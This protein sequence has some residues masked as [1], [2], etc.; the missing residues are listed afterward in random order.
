[1][2][3]VELRRPVRRLV[4]GASLV[5]AGLLL[6]DAFPAAAQRVV[7]SPVPAPTV[8]TLS[9]GIRVV[10][11]PGSS[12]PWVS[13]RIAVRGGV[14]AE[15]PD[16]GGVAGLVA[17]TLL[18]ASLDRPALEVADT[19]ARLGARVS[20][21]ASDD[22]IEVKLSV[23]STFAAPA[24]DV[25]ADLVR[26]PAFSIPAVEEARTNALATLGAGWA[27]PP[28]MASRVLRRIAFGAAHA[29]GR[30]DQVDGLGEVLA[31]D[32][33][34][35]HSRSFVP[36]NI[37]VTVAGDVDREWARN[38]VENALGN[39]PGGAAADFV[40]P[41]PEPAASE[42]VLV[43]VPGATRTVLRLGHAVSVGPQVDWLALEV[44]NQLLGGTGAARLSRRMDAEELDAGAFSGLTR[45]RAAGFFQIGAEGPSE[46]TDRVIAL[47]I[48]E[49]EGFLAEGPT[50]EEVEDLKQLMLGSLPLQRESPEQRSAQVAAFDMLGRSPGE[51]AGVEDRITAL[52]PEEVAGA[53]RRALE[54][55]RLRIVAVGDATLL[56]PA[57]AS[58]G[59][60]RIE[61]AEG[62]AL[63]LAELTPP[64][65]EMEWDTRGLRP[66]RWEYRILVEDTEIGTMVRTVTDTVVGG[67]EAFVMTSE[68]TTPPQI[69]RQ[70]T[71]FTAERF[72]PIEASF[73]LDRP[74]ASA[75][76]H[77]RVEGDTVI[78]ERTDARGGTESF[79]AP[80]IEGALIGEMLEAAL[81]ILPHEPGYGVMLPIMQV[82][83]GASARVGIGVAGRTR[84]NVPAGSSEAWV[85]EI[86]G[87][88]STQIAWVHLRAPHVVLR[89]ASPG[90]PEVLE[91]VR[92][93]LERPG[94]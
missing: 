18:R 60:L 72:R 80:L 43:H 36:E 49:L 11:V 22:W 5:S 33:R 4:F 53:A 94:G 84:V 65:V 87:E 76:A 7:P 27:H 40:V 89:L 69:L 62:V 46:V 3:G 15:P 25:V 48:E 30:T 88:Q 92:S 24:L 44:A 74:G 20:A 85:V 51:W 66:G 82:Q 73:S 68:M 90:R 6:A 1:M 28:T 42:V 2:R 83:S 21:R 13:F 67:R 79:R 91:L 39:W 71:T 32:L 56:R 58:L 23:P 26:D 61:D 70:S 64:A 81:W 86:A 57:L 8:D 93:T 45:H 63:G 19:L 34:R 35:F 50:A 12:A 37:T 14:S 77:L 38:R 54:P 16:R 52:T 78:G 29:Y 55:D 47:L 75:G 9:N 41:D 10:T 31:T 59:P 17:A